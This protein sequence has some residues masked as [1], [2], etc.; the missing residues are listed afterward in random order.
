MRYR[1]AAFAP[2]GGEEC[3]MRGDGSR[4]SG[5]DGTGPAIRRATVSDIDGILDALEPVSAEGR[6]TGSEAPLDRERMRAMFRETIETPDHALFVVED[7]GRIVG[8]LGVHGGGF[9]GVA[10]V[11]MSLLLAYRGRGLGSALMVAAIAFARERGYH[12]VVLHV[13][14]WN[15]AAI[16]LYEKFGFEREGYF[17]KHA[18]RRNG[19][20][21][22]TVQMGLLLET[23]RGESGEGQ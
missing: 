20:L 19:E 17:R 13:F 1:Q 3:V 21:W 5:E 10:G 7:A 14:P 23:G 4:T 8:S 11:G 2:I 15:E 6:W 22:D 9:R 12:K 16:A 18:R